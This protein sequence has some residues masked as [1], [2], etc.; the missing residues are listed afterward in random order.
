[1]TVLQDHPAAG[2]DAS[3]FMD[4]AASVARRLRRLI[5]A[6]DLAAGDALPSERV[7]AER[8]SVARSRV[9]RAFGE[10]EQ[11]GLI[12]VSAK[13]VRRV[14]R[15]ESN[16]ELPKRGV[17][18]DDTIGIV[19]LSG[20]AGDVHRQQPGWPSY[21]QIAASAA[22][23]G[24]GMQTLVG[25]ASDG[26]GPVG[27]WCD[28]KPSGVVVAFDC[29]GSE[30]GLA[31]LEQLAEAGVPVVAHA[32]RDPNGPLS[33]FDRVATDHRRGGELLTS[34]LIDRGC[35]RILR[36]HRSFDRQPY[37]DRRDEGY[38]KA[39]R[40]AVVEPLPTMRTPHLVKHDNSSTAE[41]FEIISRLLM[42]YLF[43]AFKADPKIDAILATTDRIAYE[44]A[45][46]CRMLG[47]EPG[48]DILI[49]GYDNSWP[50]APERSEGVPP[51]VVTIDK[52]HGDIGRGLID[53][54]MDRLNGRLPAEP[55]ERVVEPELV[56][57][58]DAELST[59]TETHL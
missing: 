29:S 24:H 3:E 40:D 47:R 36:L 44:V 39:C 42:S 11:E 52:H 59:T 9:R 33:K 5:R 38:D 12:E 25:I 22:A 14:T 18:L 28:V 45:A 37:W 48:R 53:L 6:G 1:M 27:R 32:N 54:L 20:L 55:Q 56:V 57:V 7:L 4:P 23:Q 35:K 50:Q 17:Q 26:I 13:R 8:L 58:E 41:N 10:L 34:H 16:V 46:A 2:V 51:P 31:V 43:D 21:V 19:D 30:V 15:Q 49:A